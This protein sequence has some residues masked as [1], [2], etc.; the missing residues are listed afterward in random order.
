MTVVKND[1]V[2]MLKVELLALTQHTNQVTFH[3]RMLVLETRVKSS[4]F[5]KS[6]LRDLSHFTGHYCHD[7]YNFLS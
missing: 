4:G 5:I 6:F 3:S 2:K 1:V 7:F